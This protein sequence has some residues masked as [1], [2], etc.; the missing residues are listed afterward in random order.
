MRML[1]R[2]KT[3]RYWRVSRPRS[4]PLKKSEFFFLVR[5]CC[6]APGG[7]GGGTLPGFAGGRGSGPPAGA[8]S[9]G[10]PPGPARPADTHTHTPLSPFSLSLSLSL[11]LSTP[12]PGDPPRGGGDPPRGGGGGGG[13]KKNPAI[14]PAQPANSTKI[15][16]EKPKT[17]LQKIL[18]F[19]FKL[20][21]SL[22]PFSLKRLAWRR[23][24]GNVPKHF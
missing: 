8:G 2:R 7:A 5:I 1:A 15:D 14:Q 18:F 3:E 10:G 21:F 23:E 13:E 11:S 20:N 9:G 12:V 6:P 4:R 22:K 19:F 17:K 16:P 24:F